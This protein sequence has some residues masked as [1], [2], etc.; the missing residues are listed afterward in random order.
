MKFRGISDQKS[1]MHVY[2]IASKDKHSK[3]KT[4]LNDCIK[5]QVNIQILHHLS[6]EP[7]ISVFI[8]SYHKQLFNDSQF[9][10]KPHPGTYTGF[11][12]MHT[13]HALRHLTT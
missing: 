12:D 10:V 2:S 4:S 11:R 9:W 1:P 13:S 6:E 7:W 5:E 8:Q 3:K